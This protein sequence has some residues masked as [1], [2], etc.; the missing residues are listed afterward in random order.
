LTLLWF[1]FILV[2]I[3]LFVK[4]CLGVKGKR[5]KPRKGARRNNLDKINLNLM[6]IYG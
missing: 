5:K 4:L 6:G 3:V 1:V 2:R